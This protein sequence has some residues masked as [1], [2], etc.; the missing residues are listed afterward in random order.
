[1][2][3]HQFELLRQAE[4]PEVGAL[5][6]LYRHRTGARLL[7]LSG[8]DENKVFGITFRT[9]PVD[10]TGVAHI[11]EH[12]VLCGSRRYPVKEP[13]VELVKGSLNTFLNAFTFPDKTCYP[14]A[15]QNLQDFYNLIEVY[16]DAV[17]YP[18]LTPETF[19]QEG[20]HFGLD[21]IE[22]PLVF[23]GVVLNEMKGAYSDPESLMADCAQRSLFPD[24]SYGVD[25]GGDPLRIPDLTHEALCAFHRRHYQPANAW[26]FFSGDDDPERRLLLLEEYLAAFPAEPVDSAVGRQPRFDAP[27]YLSRTYPVATGDESGGG[28]MVTVNWLLGEADPEARLGLAVL[29]QALID[30]GLGEDLVGGGL[31]SELAE[32]S[33]GTGLRGV[34][35]EDAGRIEPLVLETLERLAREGI[36]AAEVAAAINSLEFRLRENNSG[37]YP[38]GL[39]MMLRALTVWLHEGDPLAALAFEAPL[40]RIKERL[41]QPRYLEGLLRGLFLDNPHRTTVTLLPDPGMGEQQEGEESERLARQKAG[42]AAKELKTLVATNA[43][44]RELQAAP[45][46]PVALVA[47]PRLGRA[48]LSPRIKTIPREE[49]VLTGTRVLLHD[50]P[51]RG[52]AYLDLAFDLHALPGELLSFVPLFGRALFEMGTARRDY[53]QLAQLIGANTGGLWAQSLATAR[54]EPGPAAT[55]LMVRGKAML[56]QAGEVCAILGEVL[57][58]GNLDDCERFLKIVLEEKAGEEA[59]LVPAGH[60]LVATRLRAC[61]DE[62]G[63]VAERLRGATYLFFLRELAEQVRRSWPEVLDRLER[64]R[65]LLLN[66]SAMVAN[67]TVDA[68]ARPQVLPHLTGLLEL[69]PAADPVSAVW[70]PVGAAGDEGL[71]IPAQVNYMGKAANLYQHGYSLDGSAAVVTRHLANT[72]L[73]DRIRVQG[74]AYGAFCSFDLN[75]G[76]LVHLSYRDPN[77]LETLEAFDRSGAFLG[78]LELDEGE[79]TKAVIG[80][81]GDLDAYQLPD[82]KGFTSM[83]RW[84]TGTTD[85]FRQEFRDQVLD[86]R[87][88]DFR[89]M[90]EVLQRA[91]EHGRVAVLGSAE[92]VAAANASQRVR[93]TPV[94]VM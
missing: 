72:W 24:V 19:Q 56:P 28:A 48:D 88:A 20:W 59:A 46:S 47:L 6:R 40:A 63:Q 32:V 21:R 10:S 62:A 75:S 1:M 68:A 64:V 44:L 18:R 93:L 86:T 81:I 4:I 49:T 89:A 76:V 39:V 14:V 2:S 57:R 94:P 82:A 58:E 84:L 8:D 29:V 78:S 83:I 69:L 51:T 3:S 77:L 91:A 25:S 22:E 9:P 35:V 27:R 7:S 87:L 33:F 42:M 13:F 71:V 11:L 43:R 54:R 37:S 23:K 26:I 38:R 73:W 52:I 55:W 5:A 30:S 74:G 60:R 17:F 67:L 41:R 53:V 92:A 66:R 16:L 90:G 80:A 34:K 65:S 50:Q 79:L 70:T 15:S 36:E 61:F 85:A 45:D 31:E 12:A